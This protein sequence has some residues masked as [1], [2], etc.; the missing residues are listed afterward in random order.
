MAIKPIPE[1]LSRLREELT[2]ARE[3]LGSPKDR[4]KWFLEFAEKDLEKLS[5]TEQALDGY[6]L[7]AA[8]SG[9][10]WPGDTDDWP[11]DKPIEPTSVATLRRVQR[12][13]TGAVKG[14]FSDK[15]VWT[16]P[17]KNMR[18]EIN[19]TSPADAKEPHFQ[20]YVWVMPEFEFVMAALFRALLDAGKY[21]RTCA[22][23]SCGKAFVATKRQEYCSTNCSQIV[24]NEKKK[25][26]K[27]ARRKKRKPK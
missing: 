11:A 8:A 22:R 26:I 6:R 21:L 24:R 9:P 23:A 18:I 19:R 20:L 13:I 17:A 12:E 16:V 7:L 5:P 2:R 14:L 15:A 4:L 1:E 3:K 27:D 25:Q 10:G